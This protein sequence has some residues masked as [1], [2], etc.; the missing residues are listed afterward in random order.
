[1]GMWFFPLWGFVVWLL[2]TIVV[3]VSGQHL[4]VS[5][6]PV[7]VAF[8]FLGTIPLIAAVTIPIYDWR[9][10]N[11]QDR[12][13]AAILM[14]LPGVLI[15]VAILLAFSSV[16]P[17][18]EDADGLFGAWLLWAYGLVLITGLLPYNRLWKL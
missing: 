8:V 7:I 2:A 4:F 6:Q 17:N 9:R 5:D 11:L 13:T 10:V 15:D 12:P 16:Y 14:S 18:L 3:R 1:M